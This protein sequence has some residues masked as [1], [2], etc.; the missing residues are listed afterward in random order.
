MFNSA[1]V[2]YSTQRDNY[3]IHVKHDGNVEWTFPV[4]HAHFDIYYLQLGNN[5]NNNNKNTTFKKDILRSYC[6]VNI[7]Y[8]PFDR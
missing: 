4:L 8:F 2:A 7:K 6:S 5:N 1:D 3:L